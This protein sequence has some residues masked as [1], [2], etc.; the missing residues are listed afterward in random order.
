MST[1]D[2]DRIVAKRQIARLIGGSDQAFYVLSE[3]GLVVFLN[4]AM[5]ALIGREVDSLIGLDC[6]AQ[7]PVDSSPESAL[8][9][10]LTLP[11]SVSRNQFAVLPDR[12]PD[13]LTNPQSVAISELD[14]VPFSDTDKP[15]NVHLIRCIIPLENQPNCSTL[16]ALLAQPESADSAGPF[17]LLDDRAI[18]I[19]QSLLKFRIQFASLDSLWFMCGES[20]QAYR[21]MSQSQ[22][23]M[24]LAHP[25]R[26]IGPNGSGREQLAHSIHQ[27][28]AI[29][30]P[31][32][33]RNLV[34]IECR[35]M[36]YSLLESMLDVVRDSHRSGAPSAVLLA[37]LDELPVDAVTAL[38][39]FCRQ[40]PSSALCVTSSCANL[41][42]L[43]PGRPE[44]A[45]LCAR[46]DTQAIEL[47]PIVNRTQD[48]PVLV[49]AWLD[50]YAKANSVITRYRWESGF[51]DALL[52]YSWPNDISELGKTLEHA[53]GNAG[54]TSLT[55]QQL[56]V[57]VRTFA[58]HV[59]ER[60]IDSSIDLD[61]ILEDFEKTIIMKAIEMYPKNRAAAAKALNISRARLLRRLNQWGVQS[62][63]DGAASADDSPIF[64]EVTNDSI[65]ED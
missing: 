8:R 2:A 21:A 42:G 34:S 43:Y 46:I 11:P 13:S 39:V 56:P 20:P 10:W 49:A 64:T 25:F 62:E 26:I 61:A 45:S 28:R 17:A 55:E 16:I 32:Y 7:I 58:S 1:E 63:P 31:A 54:D 33:P 65:H 37:G 18:A 9:S 24:K 38:E 30:I 48:I 14:T 59:E 36:D 19:Q 47:T 52:T 35:L 60:R 51:M 41:A 6:S 22:I 15:S 27:H 4:D 44:W 3:D 29:S 23:A 53:V 57:A 40:H 5:A 50:Q 12:L